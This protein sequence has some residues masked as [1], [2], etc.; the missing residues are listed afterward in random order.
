[1]VS[2]G[3]PDRVLGDLGERGQLDV[4]ETFVFVYGYRIR[5]T[6]PLT[7]P[8]FILYSL[9]P[10]PYSL[11]YSLLYYYS[12]SLSIRDRSTLTPL[13]PYSYTSSVYAYVSLLHIRLVYALLIRYTYTLFLLFFLLSLLLFLLISEKY[14]YSVQ[15]FC[16]QFT[17]GIRNIYV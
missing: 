3:S 9:L 5:Y 17:L 12:Y 7:Y 10:T 8:P 4:Y 15:D 1:M 11:L 2:L 6:Y 14:T 13:L 16:T